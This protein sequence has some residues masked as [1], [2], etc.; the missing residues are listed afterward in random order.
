MS[1][2]SHQDKSNEGLL[3]LQKRIKEYLK[4]RDEDGLLGPNELYL[5]IEKIV[6]D[7]GIKH[8]D[9]STLEIV[10]TPLDYAEENG[11]TECADILRAAAE[12]L[13]NR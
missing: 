5:E 3:I 10:R 6:R 9:L 7:Y 12:D 8:S 4:I 13:W 11:L 1:D 2:K